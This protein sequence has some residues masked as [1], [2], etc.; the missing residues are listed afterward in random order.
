MPA[1]PRDAAARAGILIQEID[2]FIRDRKPAAA[3]HAARESAESGALSI[4]ELYALVLCPLMA[5]TGARW[6]A[7]EE[8]VWE[9]HYTSSIVRT[10]VESMHDLVAIRAAEVAPNGHTV[11][12]ACPAEEYHD[13]GLRMLADRLTLAGY[14]VYFLGA[15]LP[16]EE[17][18]AAIRELGADTVLLSASTHFHRLALRE[19]SDALHELRPDVQV[20][21]GG[22]AFAKGRA[23]WSDSEVPDMAAVLGDLPAEA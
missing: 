22:P 6:Q 8:E 1:T 13:L 9:E 2:R 14:D 23:G 3:I 18:L 7:G 19:Y 16:L 4:P 20:W 15:A 11:I 17:L 12:L 21:V 10:I 5:L